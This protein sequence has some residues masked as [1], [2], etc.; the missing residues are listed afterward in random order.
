MI[1]FKSLFF[2]Q[3]YPELT[4]ERKKMIE[5]RLEDIYKGPAIAYG[6]SGDFAGSK[7]QLIILLTYIN[8]LNPKTL[9]LFAQYRDNVAKLESTHSPNNINITLESTKTSLENALLDIEANYHTLEPSSLNHL[10]VTKCYAGASSNIESAIGFFRPHTLAFLISNSKRN[11]LLNLAAE[12]C[13]L[14]F[15]DR[16]YG[17]EIHDIN[18]L[19][20]HLAINY[21]LAPEIDHLATSFPLD[22]HVGFR[23][24]VQ[25]KFSVS[26]FL[27]TFMQL[28]SFPPEVVI[29]NEENN[30]KLKEF[31]LSLGMDGINIEYYLQIYNEV[32]DEKGFNISLHPKKNFLLLLSSVVALH[33]ERSGYLKKA[34]FSINNQLLFHNGSAVV[35]VDDNKI[36]QVLNDQQIKEIISSGKCEPSL[37]FLLTLLRQ[38][39]CE[40]LLSSV[41]DIS[42]RYR[43]FFLDIL[44]K[45]PQLTPT[46]INE[47]Y[48]YYLEN[49]EI[50]G[51][52]PPENFFANNHPLSLEKLINLLQLSS[53]VAQIAILKNAIISG[54]IMH[55]EA[56][57]ANRR[58]PRNEDI[59]LMIKYGRLNMLERLVSIYFPIDRNFLFAHWAVAYGQIETLSYLKRLGVDLDKTNVQ[60]ETPFDLAMEKN[61]YEAAVKLI[62]LGA[63]LYDQKSFILLEKVIEED[64]IELLRRLHKLGITYKTLNALQQYAAV[65]YAAVKGNIKVLY[66]LHELGVDLSPKTIYTPAHLAVINGQAD[67]LKALSDLGLKLYENDHVN[68]GPGQTLAQLAVRYEKVALLETLKALGVDLNATDN[69]GRTAIFT[70]INHVKLE[71]LKELIRLGALVNLQDNQGDTLIHLLARTI[72]AI[73]FKLDCLEI[74]LSLG[75]PYNEINNKSQKPS[76]LL[77]GKKEKMMFDSKIAAYAQKKALAIEAAPSA[78]RDQLGE[79]GSILGQ[80]R[81]ELNPNHFFPSNKSRKGD[82]AS[83]SPSSPSGSFNGP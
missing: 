34:F 40:S 25:E 22:I 78:E 70:A 41:K 26:T 75:A 9:D 17:N 52:I 48:H 44:L 53:P 43:E 56:S 59:I 14:V 16:L 64:N 60:R 23:H 27:S 69:K 2:S 39:S 50:F 31:F 61:N 51:V 83:A 12:Y 33:L 35:G 19:Y 5:Q 1:K 71:A 6:A 24:Y 67:C 62:E 29:D 37:K 3:L 46:I 15:T 55:F 54:N 28:L 63:S 57:L 38:L 21:G 45:K 76:D 18:A 58:F 30:K 4:A 36:F 82:K 47:A 8:E 11:V 42:V 20:N 77:K 10:T 66:K 65:H 74:L 49:F 73:N 13:P 32:E 81:K 72:C 79:N 80:K 7:Q 68:N